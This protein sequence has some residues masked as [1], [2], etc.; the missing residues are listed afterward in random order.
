MERG[1][2]TTIYTI[3]HS[4]RTIDEFIGLL[5]EHGIET[6]AD[7][8]KMAKSRH[9]PQFAEGALSES[10][11]ARHIAY[12]RF[13]GLGGLRKPDVNSINTAWENPSFRAYADYMQTDA[14]A[15]SLDRLIA[16]AEQSRTV[17]M[18]AEAV[19]WRCHR[20]LIGD[21]LLVRGFNVEDII[22]ENSARPHKLTAFAK[23]DGTTITY[24]G[25][26]GQ[27]LE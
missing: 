25:P 23:V 11:R 17:I 2:N 22:S 26:P 1:V 4:N 24:P 21:A 10:L 14:F 12:V 19:P 16:L 6:L 20:S 13:E 5:Q 7:V 15:A 27:P 3:G 9:N 8:R 18:C